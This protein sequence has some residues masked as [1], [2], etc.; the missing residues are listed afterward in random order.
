M[1]QEKKPQALPK[2]KHFWS[3]RAAAE[4]NAAPELILY[5][6][7]LPETCGGTK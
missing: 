6:T 4:E 2:N 1:A 7:L 5:A 3:F